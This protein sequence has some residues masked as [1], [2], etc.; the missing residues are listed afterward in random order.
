M[1]EDNLKTIIAFD[2]V[3]KKELAKRTMEDEIVSSK[4]ADD[5]SKCALLTSADISFRD[6]H[7]IS[8][9][10]L[11]TTQSLKRSPLLQN[12]DS[13]LLSPK[14]NFL[15]CYSVW[16]PDHDL[17]LFRASNL[18][19]I[20]INRSAFVTL[21]HGYVTSA[22][23]D[24]ETRLITING[25]NEVISLT[26]LSSGNTEL[27]R[28]YIRH[29]I[30][31]EYIKFI[32]DNSIIFQARNGLN[33]R[34]VSLRRLDFLPNKVLSELQSLSIPQALVMRKG[35]DAKYASSR[36][37][38]NS[39]AT[40]IYWTISDETHF[41]IFPVID[42]KFTRPVEETTKSAG[43]S[44]DISP[45]QTEVPKIKEASALTPTEQPVKPAESSEE[46]VNLTQQ[47]RLHGNGLTTEVPAPITKQRI[48]P[49]EQPTKTVGLVQTVS[50]SVK[51]AASWIWNRVKSWWQ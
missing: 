37:H 43:L 50:E 19:G 18:S 9:A 7:I 46:P 25:N 51:N 30:F 26:N 48:E 32:S 49:T 33:P 10:D 12:F 15:G 38:A 5:G 17:E 47:E 6:I 27:S 21:D 23:N 4:L 41:F 14:G 13:I 45:I 36:Y 16:L 28:L 29:S 34:E 1:I 11:K 22:F 39:H 3:Q 20:N 8:F 42:I 2:V 35:Y 40:E 24:D 31:A 44:K